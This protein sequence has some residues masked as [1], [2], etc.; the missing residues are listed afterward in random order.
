MQR[1]CVNSGP[2]Q[3]SDAKPKAASKL[4]PLQ[5]TEPV[6]HGASSAHNKGMP[7]QGARQRFKRL[8]DH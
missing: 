5:L 8:V 1:R 7:R 4:L 6:C 2:L 3:L